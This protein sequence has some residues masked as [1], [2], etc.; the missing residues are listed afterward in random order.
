MLGSVLTTLLLSTLATAHVILTYPGWRGN[1]L[2][3]NETYPF[4]MQWMYPCKYSLLR[5]P[6]YGSSIH[7]VLGHDS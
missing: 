2:I 6:R 1:N 3:E 4:G 7:S 5:S